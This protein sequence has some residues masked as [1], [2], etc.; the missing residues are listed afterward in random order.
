M[1]RRRILIVDSDDN[2]ALSVH[3]TLYQ[4]INDVDI[5]LARSADK[6]YTIAKDTTIDVVL[7]DHDLPGGSAKPL[8]TWIDEQYPNSIVY[9]GANPI[10]PSL[11]TWS[12]GTWGTRMLPRPYKSTT[13]RDH[14]VRA[15]EC[16]TNGLRG[17]LSA[18]SPP[19]IIQFM[20]LNH[21]SVGLRLRSGSDLAIVYIKTGQVTHAIWNRTLEGKEAIYPIVKMME[22]GFSSIPMLDDI[23]TSI[24]DDWQALLLEGT[25]R[26]DE[27]F[28]DDVV[29]KP[30]S[31]S[32]NQSGP[33]FLTPILQ[34]PQS[35]PP[36]QF[37]SIEHEVAR[38]IEDGFERLRSG[39][40]EGARNSWEKA[41]SHDPNNRSIEANLRRLSHLEQQPESD[42]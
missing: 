24:S 38:L 29:R 33:H 28:R 16:R 27:E 22:G 12:I 5:F 19:D 8:A 17:S 11:S 10:D 37:L 14:L 40:S 35:G 2:V 42:N 13:I 9:F 15:I 23:P 30:A 41:R 21:K 6:A 26:L 7:I 18:I 20:C 1:H 25:R 34:V 36:N 3:R 31:S 39:D 32:R 4:A